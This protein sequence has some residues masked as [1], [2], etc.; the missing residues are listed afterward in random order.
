MMDKDPMAYV[1]LRGE[2]ESS[3]CVLYERDLI[4]LENA[5]SKYPTC[6]PSED[7][8][9]SQTKQRLSRLFNMLER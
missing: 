5:L 7:L 1:V 6:S 8:S 9:L 3:S 2:D 4:L